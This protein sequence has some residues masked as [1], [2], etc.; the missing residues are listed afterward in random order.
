[1]R[2]HSSRDY[3]FPILGN[4]AGMLIAIKEVLSYLVIHYIPSLDG[5]SL[6]TLLIIISARKEGPICQLQYLT[7]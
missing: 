4:G 3:S 2:V 7:H 6:I 5:P 1:M